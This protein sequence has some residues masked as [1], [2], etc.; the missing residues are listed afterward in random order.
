ACC[1]ET[2]YEGGAAMQELPYYHPGRF[3]RIG[4]A[5]NPE[6][7]LGYLGEIHPETAERLGHG[8]RVYVAEIYLKVVFELGNQ[9]KTF[10][11]L[12]KYPGI[13][14]DLAIVVGSDV[15]NGDVV[16]D[17]RRAGGK[18]LES[19]VLFD[20]YTDEKI[21]AQYKSLAYSL[22][23]RSMERTLSDE[24]IAGEMQTILTVLEENYDA[25]LRS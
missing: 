21:G 4:L 22:V 6:I 15:R 8:G 10:V 18:L 9:D 2:L 3:A 12:P 20:V 11:P 7:T 14:R 16:R 23:F 19:V 13:E 24:D 1:I 17:M 5:G 25:K